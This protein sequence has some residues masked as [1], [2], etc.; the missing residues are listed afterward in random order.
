MVPCVG[1][2][3]REKCEFSCLVFEL[4]SRKLE[5]C[6][7]TS[8]SPGRLSLPTSEAKSGSRPNTRAQALKTVLGFMRLIYE[9]VKVT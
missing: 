9:T 6:L 8:A 4:F 2:D 1:R 5:F 7:G 3:A